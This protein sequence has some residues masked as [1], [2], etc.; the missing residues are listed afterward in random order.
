MEDIFEYTIV[1]TLEQYLQPKY[2]LIPTSRIHR[3]PLV[4][5]EQN[6]LNFDGVRH[7]VTKE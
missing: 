1:V 5:I 3:Q 2:V 4:L 7:S 6:V